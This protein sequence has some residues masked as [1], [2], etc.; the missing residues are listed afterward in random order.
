LGDPAGARIRD[1][2]ALAIN[3]AVLGPDHTMVA[4]D[5]GNLNRIVQALEDH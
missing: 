2:Q 3:E 4:A 1:R 5:R